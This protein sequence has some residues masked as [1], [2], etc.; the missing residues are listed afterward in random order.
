MS[1]TEIWEEV[2]CTGTRPPPIFGHT[3]IV[4]SKTKVILFGGV[5]N[6]MGKMVLSNEVY[7]YAV[8][9]NEWSKLARKLIIMYS[10]WSST[11]SKSSTC[12]SRSR[13]YEDD[14]LW[15]NNW[16]YIKIVNRWNVRT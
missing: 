6:D 8:Y 15:R 16:W 11:M 1:K 5:I 4:L 13:I 12:S 9:K 3:T 2:E 14:C 10:N 7:Y